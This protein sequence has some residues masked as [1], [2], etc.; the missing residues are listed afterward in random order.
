MLKLACS[1]SLDEFTLIQYISLHAT[2]VIPNR[3]EEQFSKGK[4]KERS[5]FGFIH[6]FFVLL[7]DVT[8]LIQYYRSAKGILC[9]SSR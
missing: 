1:I 6:I 8:L 4:T 5:Q 2:V 3:A 7:F 9:R